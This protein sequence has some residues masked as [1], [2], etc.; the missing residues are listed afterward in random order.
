M[1]LLVL[2]LYNLIFVDK[3]FKYEFVVDIITQGFIL[4]PLIVMFKR[5]DS[6]ISM[7]IDSEQRYKSLFRYNNAGIYVV[8]LDG[9]FNTASPNLIE[10]LGYK[11]DALI[12][13][14]FMSLIAPA[15]R[16]AIMQAFSDIIYGKVTSSSSK[17]RILHKD[18][19]LLTFDLSSVALMVEGQIEGVIGFAKDITELEKVQNKLNE[20]QTQMRHIFETIDIVLWSMD[21]R[22]NK[23]VTLSPASKKLSGYTPEEYFKNQDLWHKWIYYEDREATVKRLEDV[24]QGVKYFNN[25]EYRIVN[26]SGEIRWVESR[27]FP[28]V[29]DLGEVT[30][31]NGIIFDITQKKLVEQSKQADLELAKLVQ[32]S[33]LSLPVQTPFFSIDA[34]YIPSEQLGGDMY[35]W[36]PI[37]EHR[38]GVLIMDVMGHGIS[39]SLIC[40]SIRS[41]LKG[42]IQACPDPVEVIQELNGHMHK[43]F[44]GTKSTANFF[45]TAI[46][47][48]VDKKNNTIDYINAGHPSGLYMNDLGEILTLESTC[49]PIGLIPNMNIQKQTI[50]IDGPARLLL[51]TDGLI[52]TPGI[53]LQEQLGLVR[54]LML[55][56]RTD[57]KEEFMDKLLMF[58]GE[59][60]NAHQ[61][62]ICLLCMDINRKAE[63]VNPPKAQEY[64]I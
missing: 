6:N 9:T 58:S 41:L 14:S 24:S 30:V 47:V 60:K 63:E 50:R 10:S 17:A 48:I 62:D 23:V 20:M 21:V 27:L 44:S 57:S 38:Y 26:M 7:L 46:S 56:S 4:T 54:N 13:Q 42:I 1:I 51:Y 61:D 3:A 43:L 52:E 12:G 39:S 40:M 31:V 15:D 45:F 22:R 53:L 32:K 37:D 11:E 35:A 34:R 19:K 49:I 18:G 33:V 36:Y 59:N 16:S 55:Q 64:L 5:Q 8:N 28:S 29:N 25:L 2:N